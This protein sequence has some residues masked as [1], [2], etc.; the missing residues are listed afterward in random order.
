MFDLPSREDPH[1]VEGSMA[2]WLKRKVQCPRETYR[3]AIS[4]RRLFHTQPA[5]F[6]GNK[7]FIFCWFRHNLVLGWLKGTGR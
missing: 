2:H 7:L 1:I 6:L 4:S 3:A 5:Y